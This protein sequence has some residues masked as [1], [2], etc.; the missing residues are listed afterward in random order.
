MRGSEAK[1]TPSVQTTATSKT[2]VARV[3]RFQVDRV[4]R[5]DIK[6]A[7]YNP[8]Q[9]DDHA[10]RKLEENLRK[11]G[12][13]SP[14]VWNKRTGNLVS[15][16][17]RLSILDDLEKDDDFAT[18]V[19][20]VDLDDDEE[21]EQNI[22]FNN[23]S[24]QGTWDINMLGDV[25][26][27]DDVKIDPIRAGFDPMDLQLLF[28]DSTL[29]PMFSLE[30]QPEGVQKAATSL[31]DIQKMKDARKQ[32]KKEDQAEVDS[33]FITV[34]VF[35][36]RQAQSVFMQAVGLGKDERYIDGARLQTLVTAGRERRQ[37][38]DGFVEMSFTVTEDR[39]KLI[40]REL[41]RVESQ[42]TGKNVRGRALEILITNASPKSTSETSAD[43]ERRKKKKKKKKKVRREEAD[44]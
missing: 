19:A 43:P 31:E 38:K 3:Q 36:N 8:R 28:D 5:R 29:A 24:A 27:A 44:A 40:G 4:H 35:E 1:S 15:G 7:P 2:R 33:E 25:I 9:I 23:P 39:A 37:L 10:R 14:L 42:L 41:R 17:Q 26:S 11:R 16:H 6:N 32:F 20:V 13:L 21:R 34:V 30:N 22:F 18:D 12:L